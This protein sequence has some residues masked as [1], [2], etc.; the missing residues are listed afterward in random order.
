[1][2]PSCIRICQPEAQDLS[3]T[4]PSLSRHF[5]NSIPFSHY[6]HI[7]PSP[8]SV[9]FITKIYLQSIF[10]VSI[11]TALMQIMSILTWIATIF[12]NPTTFSIWALAH[13]N[14][15]STLHCESKENCQFWKAFA[16]TCCW[17]D[18]KQYSIFIITA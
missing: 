18:R 7:Q 17:L 4:P 6:T 11:T 8:S 1:M 9:D 10:V 2:A 3:L 12:S 16:L 15:S 5:P 13:L 14:S